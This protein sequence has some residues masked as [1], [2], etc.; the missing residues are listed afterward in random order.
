MSWVRAHPLPLLALICAATA[1]VLTV[2]P[3]MA[4][5]ASV[6]IVCTVIV[7]FARFRAP[8]I[9]VGGMVCLVLCFSVWT[10]VQALDRA[11]SINTRIAHEFTVQLTSAATPLANSFGLVATAG[12]AH[13]DAVIHAV[14]GERVHDIPVSLVG[15]L[16]VRASWGDQLV[17]AGQLVNS[18]SRSPLEPRGLLLMAT[19]LKS[20]QP[21]GGI[22]GA[23][24][25]LRE[26]FRAA[27]AGVPGVGGQLVTGLAIGDTSTVS[28][29]LSQA[30]KVASLTHLMA[31]SGANCALIVALVWAVAALIGASR[32]VRIVAS[33]AALAAFVVL[34]TPQPSVIRA[35]AMALIAL[36]A[37]ASGAP[38]RGLVMLSVA[39]IALLWVDPWL[40]WNVGFALSVTATAGLLV[41]AR[42]LDVRLRRWFGRLSLAI[43]V[44][45]AAQIACTPVLVLL[46]PN[47]ALW[48]VPANMIAGWL[49]PV[50][51]MLGLASALVLPVVP[52]LG[53]MLT[54]FASIPAAVIGHIAIAVERFPLASVA[55]VP[56]FGGAAIAALILTVLITVWFRPNPTAK[57]IVA[58]ALA[59]I[60]AG[61]IGFWGIGGWT[62][63][64][65]RP[66]DWIIAAC[67]VGQGDA[68]V[69]RD[70]GRVA[71]IDTGRT[72]AALKTCL[73][74]LEIT[75]L[76]LL[77]LTHYDQDHVGGTNA[78]VGAVDR[79]I[80]GPAGDESDYIL[81]ETLSR[82]G[83]EVVEVRRGDTGILGGSSYTVLWPGGGVET[84]NP[85]SVSITIT[86]QGVSMLFLGD[87]G[88]E[89]QRALLRQGA[90]R[91][92]D[93][94]K[95]AH[96]GSAD[97]SPELYQQLS[98]QLGLIGVGPNEYGHPTE[99]LLSTLEQLH[100]AVVRTDR[101][102]LALISPGANGTLSV[103]TELS[104]GGPQ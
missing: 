63:S 44:P 45:L 43:A 18:G 102:G 75:H 27:A 5:W 54:W 84:G 81:R 68:F 50:A 99:R 88:A 90:P 87:L 57:R 7:L 30:M 86:L 80:V 78:V 6:G 24:E 32:T 56:G 13:A 49:A 100:T 96:H 91:G 60:V 20:S 48:G 19:E 104:D 52:V 53:Q 58:G 74:K 3:E 1:L 41:L 89:A 25:Q 59:V 67:D 85:A 70:A 33:V 83:A 11:R 93:V 66:N 69:I 82:G 77:V 8:S 26:R 17:V 31:V 28:G 95:V 14:D 10:H 76:D 62:R 4:V 64:L 101:S 92:I 55:W 71:L 61:N 40:A 42:P 65:Q 72:S 15:S 29:E 98:A 36:V 79:V 22:I 51:T 2:V 94:V 39:V 47:I 23:T 38:Q 35:A 12:R 97:Q 34:V 9:V 21:I 37:L 16:G 46:S 103:W 73:A